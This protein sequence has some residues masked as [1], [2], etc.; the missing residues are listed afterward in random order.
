MVPE[1]LARQ[2]VFELVDAV[3]VY[4]GA[5][6]ERENAIALQVAA[7]LG[8][9]GI[10]GSDCHSVQGIGRACTAFER[11]VESPQSL[12]QE[13]HAGR[14]RPALDVEQGKPRLFVR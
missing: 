11:G 4:N 13:L 8:K 12:L 6:S 3:E 14:F 9:P 10:G 7:Y 2:P 5:N 1:V